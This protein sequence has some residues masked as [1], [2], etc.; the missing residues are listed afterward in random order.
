MGR[1]ANRRKNRTI[2]YQMIVGVAKKA[3]LAIQVARIDGLVTDDK[4]RLV[5]RGMSSYLYLHGGHAPR[6]IDQLLTY[7][8]M[9][10]LRKDWVKK[11]LPYFQPFLPGLTLE[12]F[13]S[14]IVRRRAEFRNDWKKSEER[15]GGR[16]E[17]TRYDNYQQIQYFTD[18]YGRNHED[19]YP[20]I[21][22]FGME[23]QRLFPMLGHKYV[24]FMLARPYSRIILLGDTR[25]YGIVSSSGHSLDYYN[26]RELGNIYIVQDGDKRCDKIAVADSSCPYSFGVDWRIIIANGR[27]YFGNVPTKAYVERHSYLTSAGLEMVN[28]YE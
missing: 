27:I 16:K 19:T 11:L 6:A 3:L 4:G 2:N 5:I 18:C 17:Q 1:S 14:T 13:W 7:H 12:K 25:R 23:S 20:I 21:R 26:M 9:H 22:C 28:R 8:H 10:Q 24:E 15:A